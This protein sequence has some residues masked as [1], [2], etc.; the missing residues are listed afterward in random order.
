MDKAFIEKM[1]KNLI[2]MKAEILENLKHENEELNE[3]TSK[4]EPSD[5]ADL[6]NNDID[7]RTLETLSS[8]DLK[9]LNL[10]ESALARIENGHY[11][12]CLYSGKPI[13]KE[14]LEAI[15]Y[16]LYTVEAQEMLERKR[17]IRA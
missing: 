2:T 13:P 6:A 12:I 1:K 14:R 9:R 8:Q 17:R 11:G 7:R 4:S 15:P 5:D 3:I 10:V 16:A